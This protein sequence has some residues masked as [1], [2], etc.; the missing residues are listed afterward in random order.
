MRNYKLTIEYDG[1]NFAGWQRLP[2]DQ[3]TVQGSVESAISTILGYEITIDG[4]GRTD[5]GVHAV[6]QVA[7]VSTAGKLN[8][9]DFK[10]RLNAILP[11]GI[12]IREVEL[13]KNSFHSRYDAKGKK[14]IYTID[15]GDKAGVF[16]RRYSYHYPEKL[17]INEMKKASRALIGTHD[18]TSFSGKKD[19]KSNT[20][21]INNIAIERRGNL[22][23]ITYDGNGFLN[24]MV[25]ILTGTLLEVGLGKI[26]AKEI[27]NILVSKQRAKA[28]MTAPSKGLRL[29]EV[30]Y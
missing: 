15:C 19:H 9:E 24:Q 1:T 2:G 10:E 14:Y 5:A 6:A 11:V 23:E 30:Y 18:F 7:N 4:S 29:E 26:D 17:D 13:V 8:E 16:N 27:E 12:Q 3:L 20:R 21:T 25:R 22:I 28:G